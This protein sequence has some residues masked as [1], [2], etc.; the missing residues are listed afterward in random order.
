[1]AS[2]PETSGELACLGYSYQEA[3]TVQG[4]AVV[5]LSI[6]DAECNLGV[7]V[8]WIYSASHNFYASTNLKFRLGPLA[9]LSD[10]DMNSYFVSFV[11]AY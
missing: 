10:T 11:E 3:F 5:H 6:L 1:M 4:H 7:S 2:V 9:N 8:W